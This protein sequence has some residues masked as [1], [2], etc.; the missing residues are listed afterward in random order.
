SKQDSIDL[1]QEIKLLKTFVMESYN[2]LTELRH[3][4][5]IREAEA[6]YEPTSRGGSHPA[7]YNPYG[8]S[9]NILSNPVGGYNSYEP[10]MTR[11]PSTTSRASSSDNED[12]IPDQGAAD[13]D[14]DDTKSKAQSDQGGTGPTR[15]SNAEAL[16]S[17]SSL[18]PRPSHDASD[19]SIHRESNLLL[20]M[21]PF[22]P[23]R[24]NPVR[25][26]RLISNGQDPGS[27]TKSA[28]EEA[29]NSVRL[30]LDKWTTSGSAPVSNI[31]DEE[32]A[33]EKNR[34]GRANRYRSFSPLSDA[35]R[36]SPSPRA[37]LNNDGV[38]PTP[39]QKPYEHPPRFHP[40]P[41]PPPLD[42]PQ[43]QYGDPS[44]G[45]FVTVQKDFWRPS[46]PSL[47]SPDRQLG[48]AM[49]T[50]LRSTRGGI[51]YTKSNDF[52]QVHY[53]DHHPIYICAFVPSHMIPYNE[54]KS[55]STELDQGSIRK[56]ALDLLGYS[57]RETGTGKFL[58]SGDLELREIEEL[59]KLSYQALDRHCKE[60]SR[61]V[62]KENG[63]G[64]AID[65][66][67]STMPGIYADGPSIVPRYP[68]PMP[69]DWDRHNPS[70][71]GYTRHRPYTEHE[72]V[73]P[74]PRGRSQGPLPRHRAREHSHVRRRA[75][76]VPTLP[77]IKV[78]RHEQEELKPIRQELRFTLP[79]AQPTSN[80]T[81]TGKEA[82]PSP[83]NPEIPTN[84]TD[85]ELQ[86]SRQKLARLKKRKEEAEKVKD[87]ATAADL[88]NYAIPDLEAQ[89]EQLLKQQNEKQDKDAPPGSKENVDKGS[90]HA[91]MET[92]SEYSDDEGGS[93]I[94][95]L[96]D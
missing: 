77:P 36:R 21:V 42:N 56:E 79:K 11:S 3:A 72:S 87:I 29:I 5:Q 43:P 73:L 34:T 49:L 85:D 57:Y 20:Q 35:Y 9:S 8:D 22:R 78:D 92:E 19:P 83:A 27:R 24:Y 75:M 64:E 55:L 16:M 45:S 62:I 2:N 39:Y 48:E 74:N 59:V 30:L 37:E 25:F 53:V 28:T 76:P 26:D 68:P 10:P 63:W 12:S 88:M 41:P 61:A 52:K 13:D 84:K 33:T 4:E 90:H 58:I 51:Y 71:S 70:Y 91:E 14:A 81:G 17:R 93:G 32:A 40:I 23:S 31:L 82:Q 89:I 7:V 18:Q 94:E 80:T 15:A 86:K 1:K 44:F 66:M 65:A 60:R 38:G 67:N 47:Q 69:E 46:Y 50:A 95:D 96:Y 6:R 54:W